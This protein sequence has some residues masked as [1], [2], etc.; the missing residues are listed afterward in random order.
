MKNITF[1]QFML[2]YNFR[3][4]NANGQS[5]KEKE[6]TTIIRINYPW[7]DKSY[8][9]DTWFEFGIDDFSGNSS[10]LQRIMS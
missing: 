10:K 8:Y 7:S 5:D 4:Y 3:Y 9:A 2:T 1:K 6:D